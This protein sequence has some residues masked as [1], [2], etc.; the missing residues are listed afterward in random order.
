[1]TDGVEQPAKP[2]HADVDA[3]IIRGSA[4]MALSFGGRQV[5]SILTT[6]ILVRLIE[7]R[8]FGLVALAWALLFV[9]ERI[10]GSGLE[11]AF[12]YRR[13]DVQEA[14]AT[15]AV[16]V[17]LM[18]LSLLALGMILAPYYAR[19]MHEPDVTGVFRVMLLVPF[20]RSLGIVPG[21]ILDR[22]LTFRV[23]MVADWTAA[24]VQLGVAVG[25][26]VAGLGVW[27]IVI[28]HVAAS[29]VTSGVLWVV[30]PWRPSPRLASWSMLRQLLRY[31]RFVSATNL[32]NILNGALDTQIVGRLLGATSLGY[33]SVT[34]RVAG[35]PNSMVTFVVGRV[36]FPA[37]SILRDD[38]AAFRRAYV[39]N[40]QRITL[41][42]LPIAVA[43]IVA[44]E[45]IV[46]TLLGERYASGVDV[47]R[48]AAVHALVL[49]LFSPGGE[50]MK[51]AG[52]PHAALVFACVYPVIGFPAL[53]FLVKAYGIEGGA[54]GI[55]I[56]LLGAG[57]AAF[58]YVQRL[59]DTRP[60]ELARA[61]GPTALCAALTGLVLLGLVR[62]TEGLAPQAVFALVVVVGLCVYAGAVM[63]FARS[64]VSTVLISVRGARA[65]SAR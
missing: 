5:V 19:V 3:R 6:L 24:L 16:F 52:K 22:Q 63:L 35:L 31:G 23:R 26:A 47:L 11:A 12:I 4:W 54:A 14:A 29:A 17:P 8:A 65:Q 33:Y 43:S 61:L 60:R 36:M 44:A 64:T 59:L 32:V 21:A 38:V 48:L 27:S 45:P 40:L 34:L 2:S 56:A 9:I 62:V 39:Q 58:V 15:A 20:I 1:M 55:V 42:S 51:A 13:T 7:P 53:Y 49:S 25:L 50:V 18:S 46:L 30:V 37:Y 28:G 57:G 10:Q 41:V